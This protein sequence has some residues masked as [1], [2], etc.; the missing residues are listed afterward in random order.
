[1]SPILKRYSPHASFDDFSQPDSFSRWLRWAFVLAG[2]LCVL[3]L[4]LCF[5][6]EGCGKSRKPVPPGQKE[7]GKEEA[8]AQPD[9]DL[10]KPVRE[11]PAAFPKNTN[12]PK[13]K[14][15]SHSGA[16]DLASFKPERDLIRFEDQRVWFESDHQKASNDT[17]DDHLINRAM[18]IPLK[19]LVNLVEAKK[20]HLKIH[21]VYRS[22]AE[23]KIHLAKSLHCEGRAIDLTADNLSL[24]ELSKLCWQA[25]FD[26]VLYEV[27]K[28]SGEHVHCS[29]KRETERK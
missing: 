2:L 8:P 17:E 7:P 6:L 18:E 26:F 15:T 19:R 16:I 4:I 24:S 12:I 27:P 23:N 13:G 21:D 14:E 5:C 20:G 3:G 11:A 29:V 25:G 9:V 22:A 1:M 28:N 10:T